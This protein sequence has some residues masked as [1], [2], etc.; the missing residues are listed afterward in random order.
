MWLRPSCDE[1]KRQRQQREDSRDVSARVRHASSTSGAASD[2]GSTRGPLIGVRRALRV[3]RVQMTFRF[4]LGER[5]SLSIACSAFAGSSRLARRGLRRRILAIGAGRQLSEE[6]RC[7]GC[8]AC[9]RRR[10]AAAPTHCAKLA[11]R[12]SLSAMVASD[13]MLRAR[14]RI[15]R[16]RTLAQLQRL[17]VGHDGPAVLRRN[18]R[19]VVRH[20]AVS[21][22]SSH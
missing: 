12:P 20:R 9:R 19:R 11:G 16:L 4:G 17:D 2:A 13:S 5:D 1:R 3:V 7:P 8:S 14:R 6:F 22:W 21:V 10:S 18:L 15:R